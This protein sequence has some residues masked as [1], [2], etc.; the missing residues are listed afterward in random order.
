MRRMSTTIIITLTLLDLSSQTEGRK[1]G[2]EG[3]VGKRK[4]ERE[5]SPSHTKK[6]RYQR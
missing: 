1:E 4:K 5:N 2:K 6:K 3:L